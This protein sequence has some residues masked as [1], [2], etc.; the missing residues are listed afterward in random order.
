MA[1][2]ALQLDEIT[3]RVQEQYQQFPY[4]RYTREQIS[5]GTQMDILR[6]IHL[7]LF[8][9]R[10]LDGLKILDA[11][12]GTGQTIMWLGVH[13]PEVDIL[14]IDI[15]K[16]S[17]DLAAGYAN[18]WDITNVRFKHHQIYD[19]EELGEEFDLIISTG[20]LHHLSDPP[21]GLRTLAS[22]LKPDGAMFLMLYGLYG[23]LGVYVAQDLLRLLDNGESQS[24]RAPVARKVID[25]LPEGHQFSAK[26]WGDLGMEGDSGL[27][28]LLLH[29]QDRAYTVPD[30]YEFV[31]SAGLELVGW[32]PP[33][34][35][36]AESLIP[37]RALRRSVAQLDQPKQA[38]LAELLRCGHKRHFFFVGHPGFKADTVN[39]EGSN[40]LEVVPVLSPFT[41]ISKVP[42][43]EG[44]LPQWTI[45]SLAGDFKFGRVLA[46]WELEALQLCQP[47]RTLRQIC[48]HP[49]VR[50]SLRGVTKHDRREAVRGA[51]RR[52][53]R[54]DFILLT[55]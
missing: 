2:E 45:V 15:S 36:D 16:P 47:G 37:D 24:E 49:K 33:S 53:A 31:E 17:I 44:Q 6:H 9:T 12:C 30:I 55:R 52:Y 8:P 32:H 13:H 50:D 19:V 43:E 48:D 28:D 11:G 34:S 5:A 18:E 26:R 40:W 4:P 14:G 42:T 22:V 46:P 41:S 21:R 20:V 29:P 23:R 7:R 51:V 3:Q 39:V 1:A 38:A 27:V 54:D 35:Y 10:S 25:A